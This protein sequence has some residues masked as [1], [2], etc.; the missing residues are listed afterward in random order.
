[1]SEMT[2]AAKTAR[3]SAKITPEGV[4]KMRERIGVL[5]PQAAPFNLEATLDGMRHFANAYGDENPLYCDESYGKGTRWGTQLASPLFVITMGVSEIK[6]IRPEIRARGAHA[7]AGVHEFFSGDEMEWF[8]PV[9]PGDRMSKRH[10]LSDVEEK[11]NS[12]M[13][14]GKSVI[15]RYRADYTNQRGELVA[16]GRYR[17]VRV[18]RDAAKQSKKY[19][20][21]ERPKYSQEQLDAIDAAYANQPPPRG[22]EDRYWEDVA[23]GEEMPTFAKGPLTV[24]DTLCWMR[25]WGA[26]VQN[27]RLAWK[28]RKKAPG[29][30]DKNEFGAWDVVERVHWDDRAAAMVGN[31]GAYDFGRMRSAFLTHAITNWM[32]DNAWLW[33]MKTEYR[34][35]NFVG[36]MTWVKGRVAARSVEDGHHVVDLQ[37]ACENQRGEVSAPGFARVI[38]PS[39]AAGPAQL[40]RPNPAEDV[41][42]IY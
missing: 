10:Y 33:R 26:G 13:G 32:G 12:E 39:R 5:V 28:H 22:A 4:A 27:S 17:F 3:P 36:D 9:Q 41:P 30:Y 25:G 42:L 16:I 1:M 38:L 34:R 2:A 6:Q 8:R 18:E 19:T 21:T 23:V 35:F 37:L 24:T 11:A 14:G 40:P 7:L 31:P 29:F 20:E 15:I